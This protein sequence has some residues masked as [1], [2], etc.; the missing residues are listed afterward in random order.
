M[1]HEAMTSSSFQIDTT[2]INRL[3]AKYGR[4]AQRV[5]QNEMTTGF[6][7]AGNIAKDEANALIHH[8]SH[9]LEASATAKTT[10]SAKV[11]QSVV[12]WTAKHAGWVN[13]GRGPVFA[14]PGH[15]LRFVIDGEVFFRRSVGPAK[16]QHFA[17]RGL[18]NARPKIQGRLAAAA[19]RFAD[20]ANGR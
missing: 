10:V 9:A 20:W 2:E 13:D 12:R 6:I 18:E 17:E 15:M 1:V 8:K 7:E 19:G 4:E 5:F 16:A 3:A 11:V 14:R